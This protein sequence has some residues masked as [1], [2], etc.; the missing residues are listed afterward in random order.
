M[1]LRA[2]AACWTVDPEDPRAPPADVWEA[3]SPAERRRV[4]DSLPSELPVSEALPPE[5][6][7]HFNAKVGARD[8]LGGYFARTGRRVYV[9]SE[10]PVYYPGEKMFA[11]D[12]IA[13][14]DVEVRERQKWTVLDEGKGLDFAFEVVVSGN[15]RK[16]LE[17][18]VQR[19][20]QLGIAEYFVFD[21]AYLRL[22]GYRLP[23]PGARAYQPVL[24]QAGMYS[25][26]VLGLDLRVEGTRLRF[27]HASAPIPDANELIQSLQRMV[28]DVEQRMTAAEERA[29]E[30]A[31]L[32]AEEAQLRAEA[33]QKLAE[34]ERRLADVER[35]L[36]E[37]SAEVER[38]RAGRTRTGKRPRAK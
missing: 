36:A 34:T 5:G 23:A 8:V 20:A 4:V 1:L 14:L 16:D 31:Q 27:Y 37:A 26:H 2:P 3:M 19:Y 13:V 24:A 6:D 33:E 11:P 7:A 35:R 30:E 9:A 18:N 28:D 22:R 10:L 17:E 12:V 15:R 21:R 32:R 38:L 29:A 25:S